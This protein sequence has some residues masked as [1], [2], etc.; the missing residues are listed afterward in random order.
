MPKRRLRSALDADMAD[1][2]FLLTVDGVNE[3]EIRA[4]FEKS[5][6]RERYEEIKRL[7]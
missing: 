4:Y 7:S 2:R 6:L 5:G 3:E 1:V